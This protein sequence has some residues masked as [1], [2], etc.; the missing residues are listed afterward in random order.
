MSSPAAMPIPT[1]MMP[2]PSIL[3]RDTGSGMSRVTGVRTGPWSVVGRV[4][5]MVPPEGEAG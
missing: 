3:R 5:A 1:A 4:N 2:G